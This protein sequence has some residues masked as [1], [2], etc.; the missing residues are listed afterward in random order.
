MYLIDKKLTNVNDLHKQAIRFTSGVAQAKIMNFYIENQLISEQEV[1][2]FKRGRNASGPGRKNIDAKTYHLAT[3]FEA[4]I[5]ALYLNNLNR[6]DEL[7]TSG[8]QFI[9]EGDAYGKNS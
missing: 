4:L 9:E 6:A 8:I 3:G 7:V 1:D 2:L 5:G